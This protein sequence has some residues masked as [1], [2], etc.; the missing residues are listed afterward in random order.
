MPTH[1]RL[2]R[3]KDC[4]T[5]SNES[6][7][8]VILVEETTILAIRSS[9]EATC[10][11]YTSDFR[12]PQKDKLME[13]RSKENGCQET[14][15]PRSIHLQGYVTWMWLHTAIENCPG[16]SIMHEPR[17]LLCSGRYFL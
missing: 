4:Q 15:L 14:D 7:V 10:V 6:E 12:W 13:L 11:S 16:S 1:R 17:V 8:R 5:P 2:R 3:A 9:T